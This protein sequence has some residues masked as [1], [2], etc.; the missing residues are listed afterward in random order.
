MQEKCHEIKKTELSSPGKPDPCC[1]NTQ[2][3]SIFTNRSR[4]LGEFPIN[5]DL[6]ITPVDFYQKIINLL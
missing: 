3:K 1:C 2:Q 6:Y 4:K 5:A